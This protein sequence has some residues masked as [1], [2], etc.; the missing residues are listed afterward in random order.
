MAITNFNTENNTFRKLMGSGLCYRVPR[1]QRDYSWEEKQW[2]DLWLDICAIMPRHGHETPER[3]SS[4][5]LG[6]L[7]LESQDGK[8]F[9]VIDGQ[10]RLTTFSLIVLA[11]LKHLKRLVDKGEDPENN[12]MRLEQIR[13]TYIGYLDP[14]TLNAKNK[15]ELNRN[16]NSYYRSYLV[17]LRE[18]LPNSGFNES[19][20]LLGLAFK[21]F[22][23]QVLDYIEKQE[24]D[25]GQQLARFIENM[26][27]RLFFTVITVTNQLNAYK[28]FETLNE[29]GVRLSP[30]DLIKNYL[31]SV[32][33]TDVQDEQDELE[34]LDERWGKIMERLGKEDF[35]DFL[36]MSWNSRYGSGRNYR[37]YQRSFVRQ[38]DL[39]KTICEK[40]T[41][42]GA[43]FKLLR[44][45]EGDLDAYLA[46]S[47]PESSKWSAEAKKYINV[48]HSFFMDSNY[49]VLL[50]AVHRQI[51][52]HGFTDKDFTVLLRDIMVIFL[53]SFFVQ[54][55]FSFRGEGQSCYHEVTEK[56]AQGVLKSRK[57]MVDALRSLYI[58]DKD[59]IAAFSR[60][61]HTFLRREKIV[62]FI[63][64]ALETHLSNKAPAPDS[65]T[66]EHVLPRNAEDG[67]GG[68]RRD[69]MDTQVNRLGNMTLMPKKD[70]CDV[71]IKG[72]A[73]KRKKFLE[74]SFAMTLKLA[75][76]NETW[77]PE[78]IGK[79]QA[80]M[81]KQAA[82]IW[83]ISQFD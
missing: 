32:L 43:V 48:L 76:E 38:S 65:V 63:L 67:W 16:N 22:E 42:R 81:A 51:G 78:C 9:A 2:D 36:H 4:H 34:E 21:W 33:G 66:I 68:F 3:D 77:T 8:S 80:W 10:Q 47:S 39:F 57:D 54:G 17:P 60:G 25:P 6:Y 62:R 55:P 12:K 64:C 30:V 72:Y 83:R 59:F 37:S 13:Q 46:L 73:E 44:E 45:M 26:S 41:D 15:L 49:F 7:V 70:N 56:M 23:K 71:G 75:K 27:D 58:D 74:S 69:E 28:V 5:Y 35:S 14:V 11:C 19:S 24:G 29:R 82:A 31:F 20:Y 50:L 18:E 40:V 61:K 1:F 53:R 52:Q 79:R